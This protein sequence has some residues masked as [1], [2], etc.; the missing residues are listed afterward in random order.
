[1]PDCELYLSILSPK[2]TPRELLRVI[3]DLHSLID[4]VHFDVMD[5]KFVTN[6]TT[7]WQT[8]ELLRVLKKSFPQLKYSVHLMAKRP[9]SYIRRYAAAGAG[10]IFFHAESVKFNQLAQLAYKLRKRRVKVGVAINPKTGVE[11][12][13]RIVD[14]LDS[15]LIM[16][17]H[18][19]K[20]GQ[21]FILETAD[22]VKKL[23]ERFPQVDVVVDGGIDEKHA[24]LLKILGARKI[25]IGSAILKQKHPFEAAYKIRKKLKQN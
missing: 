2:L 12:F 23:S 13:A 6:L 24:E 25:V 21:K 9:E 10:E 14:V 8:P 5:G 16:S 7:D 11:H 19:G 17:V 3:S 15:V 20:S 18:P 1:M 4:G 22:K